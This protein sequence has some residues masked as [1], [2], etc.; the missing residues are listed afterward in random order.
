MVKKV[1]SIVFVVRIGCYVGNF[2]C[3]NFVF[4]KLDYLE[5]KKYK[6]VILLINFFCF[7][8]DFFLLNCFIFIIIFVFKRCLFDSMK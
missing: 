4:V 8:F 2:C 3:L 1:G 6:R 5:L 7:I